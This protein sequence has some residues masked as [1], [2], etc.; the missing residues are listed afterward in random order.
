MVEDV[1]AIPT[2]VARGES[3]GNSSRYEDFRCYAALD[4]TCPLC[5]C[6]EWGAQ[7][8]SGV[9]Q[10]LEKWGE[11]LIVHEVTGWEDLPNLGLWGH[12]VGKFEKCA[13][14]SPQ[15]SLS[16]PILHQFGRGLLR[17]IAVV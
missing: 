13:G 17:W 9:P 10:T 2:H 11:I 7:T 15:F 1:E 6:G 12:L 5:M 14:Y 4:V 16:H 8:V 3:A